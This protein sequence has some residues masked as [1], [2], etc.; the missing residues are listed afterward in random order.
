MTDHL[1]RRS[2]VPPPFPPLAYLYRPADAAVKTAIIEADDR[3][4]LPDVA[5]SDADVL[6]WGRLALNRRPSARSIEYASRRE[7]AIRRLRTRPPEGY[8]LAALHRLPPVR[9]PG[10]IRRRVRTVSL[11]GVLA[12]LV[13]NDAA[14]GG[15]PRVIDAVVR[16]AG[17]EVRD[18]RVRPSGDGSALVRLT[19]ADGT[20]AEL[21]VAK[22]ELPKDPARGF[23][24]LTALADGGVERVPR[25]IG[26]GM[27]GEAKWSTET[28]AP[29]RHVLTLDATLL[30]DVI[31][32]LATMPAGAPHC[33]AIEDHLTEVIDF[34]P[35]HAAALRDVIA[36]SRRWC[37]GLRPILI[38][39]DLWLNNIFTMDG[40]LSAVFDWDTWH[41]AGLPGTDLLTLL[42]ADA[43]SRGHGDVGDLLS[44]DFWRRPE[45]AD[46]FGAYF[47][48]R[49]EPIPDAAGQAAIA[50]GWW[51]SRMAGALHRGLR[52]IDDPAWVRRNMDDAL[53]RFERLA[54]ELG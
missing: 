40:R 49:G 6:L 54:E 23:A 41:P 25:P 1:Q 8:R 51:A 5:A 44:S 15:G 37:A 48:A 36:A 24:A 19:L 47:R 7:L 42:A 17:S 43:R 53:P 29:G 45:V 18:P 9:R 2:R 3:W 35:E 26:L 50:T 22:R 28:V 46:A 39:G 14:V 20:R 4:A 21:R 52:F 27:T 11:G 13:R 32:F 33:T 34:F 16:A 30:E 31:S 38:H 10:A 12:E